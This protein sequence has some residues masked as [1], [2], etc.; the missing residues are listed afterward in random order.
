MRI[1]QIN[2]TV[3]LGSTGRIAE[4]IGKVFLAQGHESFI[5]YGR[6]SGS[7]QS[8]LIKIGN[9]YDVYKHGFKSAVFDR[10]G[11]GSTQATRDLVEK[12]KIIKP[13]VIG[14]HNIHGYY[15]NIEILFDYLS[16]ANIPV[17]WTLHDSW[18]FT[19]HCSYFENVNCKKWKTHCYECPKTRFY[20]SSYLIDNSRRNFTDKKALFNAVSKI[21]IVTPSNWLKE[22]VIESFL[23][24]KVVTIHNGI[25]LNVFKPQKVSQQLMEGLGIN[26]KKIVLGVARIWDSR[27]GLEDF[28]QLR[29]RLSSAY[30]IVLVGLSKNQKAQLPANIVGIERA[31]NIGQLASLFNASDV[32]VNPTYLDNFP[33]TNIEALACGTPVVTYNTGGSPEA[34]DEQTGQV[35][36][37]GDIEGLATAIE[38]IFSKGKD[39]YRSLCRNR[40]KK[41]FDKDER[42][43]DYL[44]EY[45]RLLADS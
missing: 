18:P 24:H 28:I 40:A 11:F 41:Y 37:K 42:Y 35:V 14:L 8:K 13:D 36:A 25:D 2:T 23:K 3:N 7:S 30:Q 29:S 9:Q 4:N 12:I 45:E 33:T 16:K 43:L 20:P 34:I 15:L 31:E 39:H 38:T 26:D 22:L 5:A 19:G 44:K 1:L 6:G 10:H 17:I 27:K 21:T 32:F